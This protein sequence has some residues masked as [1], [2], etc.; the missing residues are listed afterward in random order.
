[1][2]P[3][4]VEIENQSAHAAGMA[5]ASLEFLK[6]NLQSLE[7]VAAHLRENQLGGGREVALAITNLQ[8]SIMWLKEAKTK[9]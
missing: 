7:N 5:S 3:D 2:K 4:D 8:Q 9:I 1:M 6:T